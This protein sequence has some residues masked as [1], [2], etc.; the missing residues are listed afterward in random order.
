MVHTFGL[1]HDLTYVCRR[2]PLVQKKYQN[3]ILDDAPLP[4][5]NFRWIYDRKRHFW[6]QRPQKNTHLMDDGADKSLVQ[7]FYDFKHL[8]YVEEQNQSCHLSS[9]SSRDSVQG[10]WVVKLLVA[11]PYNR[12]VLFFLHNWILILPLYLLRSR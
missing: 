4:A 11:L 10:L 2:I 3:N 7:P 1:D 6:P 8:H 5:K 12:L 9:Y